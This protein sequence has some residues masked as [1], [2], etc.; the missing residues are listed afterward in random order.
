[1]SKATIKNQ[2][3]SLK[4]KFEKSPKIRRFRGRR[5]V[6]IDRWQL[7][8]WTMF[9]DQYHMDFSLWLHPPQ[10]WWKDYR[11]RKLRGSRSRRNE[12]EVRERQGTLGEAGG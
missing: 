7:E 8:D 12:K 4:K 3:E 5:V 2:I 1:M 10:E 11:L 9:P 6:P